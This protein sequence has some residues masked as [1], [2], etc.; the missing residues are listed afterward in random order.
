MNVTV[1]LFAIYQETLGT[2]ELALNVPDG[3]SVIALLDSL[4][5]KHPELKPWRELTRFGQNLTFVD[6]ETLL[7]E[8]D[9]VVF[10]PPVSGG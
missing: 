7:Q 9:E 4:L 1:K 8:G 5:A 10:I 2:E 3:T 6:P